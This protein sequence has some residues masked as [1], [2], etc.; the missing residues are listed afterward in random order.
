[1][2]KPQVV[3]NSAHRMQRRIIK[4]IVTSL[5]VLVIGLLIAIVL[6]TLLG[7]RTLVIISGSM[8]P[9]IHTGA[10]AVLQPVPSSNLQLGD[11]VAHTPGTPGAVPIVHR[12]ISITTRNGVRFYQTKGDAN[13]SADADEFTLP[14]TAW[15]LWYNIPLAGYVVAFASSRLGI[16]TLIVV[17]IVLLS[18][19]KLSDWR[20][21]RRTPPEPVR[22]PYQS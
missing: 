14:T 17:P 11:V 18:L 3:A 15:R 20:K 8:E 4:G 5:F 2:D 7:D 16:I 10:A 13:R 21:G 12:I 19:M 6:P 22:E 1:M 9:T